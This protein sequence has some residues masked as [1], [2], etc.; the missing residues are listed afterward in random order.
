MCSHFT[1]LIQFPWNTFKYIVFKKDI[2]GTKSMLNTIHYFY[3][4]EVWL[5]QYKHDG[6]EQNRSGFEMDFGWVLDIII[7]IIF[8]VFIFLSRI[9]KWSLS[10][11]G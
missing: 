10:Q 9:I 6:Q 3:S 7:A 1:V 8:S 11:S 4:P 2:L 5:E